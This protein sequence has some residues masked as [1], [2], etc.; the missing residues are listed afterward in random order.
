MIH[1]GTIST[2]SAKTSSVVGAYWIN[3][4]SRLRKITAPGVTA[5]S[6]PGAEPLGAERRLAA[7]ETL[8]VLPEI[9][10]AARQVH[11]DF[12]ER[13]RE[14]LGI[15]GDEVDRRHRV[16]RLT[17]DKGRDVLMVSRNAADPGGGAVPPLL[18]QQEPLVVQVEGRLAPEFGGEA[19]V[20]RQRRD[21]VLAV[22]AQG[23]AERVGVETDELAQALDREF[24]AFGGRGRQMDRPIGIGEPKRRRRQAHRVAREPGAQQAVERRRRI[25]RLAAG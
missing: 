9:D 11:A 12:G 3:S 18:L 16:Q 8:P 19:P 7:G 1:A 4:I 23:G 2:G 15:G 22:R 24:A 5:T 14:N 25:D 17:R 6:L 13:R 21:D 10:R 20:L